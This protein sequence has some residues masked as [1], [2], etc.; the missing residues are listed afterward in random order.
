MKHGLMA[1]AMAAAALAACTPEPVNTSAEASRPDPAAVIAPLYAPYLEAGAQFPAFA[2]QAPWSADLGAELSAMAARAAA[3]GA[4]ILDFDPLTGAQDHRLS[5]LNVRLSG[6]PSSE[7]AVVRVSF[8]NLGQREEI[9]YDLI[10]EQES[11]RVD[12]I[13]GRGWDLRQIAEQRAA[14]PAPR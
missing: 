6:A 13:R 14:E 8:T 5:D 9:V 3:R 4:P 11:W 10:W 2:Q 12:N 1:L 7:H